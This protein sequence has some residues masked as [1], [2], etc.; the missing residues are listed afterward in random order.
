VY[1]EAASVLPVIEKV[2]SIALSADW[3]KD[4]VVVDNC[5]TDG[6][7]EQLKALAHP[8]VRVIYHER[9]MGKGASVRTGF[10]RAYGEFGVIQD[11]DF[12][13]DPAELALFTQKQTETG[14]TAIFGSRTLGGRHIYKYARNYWGVR[15]L[16]T[17]TNVLFRGHLSDVAVATKMVRCDVFRALHLTGSAFEL[18]F[19]LPCKLL[20][21]RHHIVEVP[22]S[23]TPRTIEE[24]KKIRWTDGL[25]ALRVIVKERFTS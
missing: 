12:E 17:L 20:K 23:Y 1:N 19:E 8:D 3:S 15:L 18:D 7:R 24:G 9:N 6:T 16:T 11:A 5:S 21:H 25:H 2:R 22:V 4:I 14:A 13:Y 10:A